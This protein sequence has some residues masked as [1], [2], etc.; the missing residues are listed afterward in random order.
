MAAAAAAAVDP[1][2]VPVQRP[3][4]TTGPIGALLRALGSMRLA[5]WLLLLL[6]ALTWLGTLAQTTRST[7]EVQREYF[8]SWFVLAELEL[9][10]WGKPLW[11]DATGG[12]FK[13]K[14]P[15]PGAYPVM[16][17]LFANLL[18]G[19]FL[20]MRWSLRNLGILVTHVG[21]ALLLVAGFVKMHYSWSGSLA[22]YE[23]PA[24][25][26]LAPGRV[27]Q[28][29]V[30]RSFQEFELA[31]LRQV[32]DRIEE[33]VVP[34]H[35]L[36]GARHGSVLVRGDGLPF[37]IEV[38]H[39]VDFAAAVPKG[40]MVQSQFPE[41]DGAVLLAQ[42]WPKGMQPRSEGEIA[43]CYVTVVANSGERYEAILHGKERLPDD[44]HRYPFTFTV[45]GERYGLDLRHT[46]F[47]LPFGLRLDKFQKLDHP[48]TMT[49]RDFRSFVSVLGGAAARPAEIFMNNPLRQD[50]YVVYQTNWGPQ[51]R[52]GP[53]WLSEFEV[54][55]N[56]SDFW[57]ALA[58][59]VIFVGLALHF[60]TK[61]T[62]F[63]HSSTRTSL[64]PGASAP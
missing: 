61:L 17:L 58:C 15:L 43:G 48:G 35:A 50:G 42:Q 44:R 52:G 31:V 9:S 11:P 2:L 32:G 22:L 39:W 63:L 6:A 24:D 19:G 46:M 23:T 51:P 60:L 1:V 64:V 56:P 29:A 7:Y 26:N 45:A 53:P 5:M 21:I 3:L 40:P 34:E 41:I 18:V 37:T 12:G 8:E 62:R 14:I 49:P 28:S 27:Y 47:E 10:L 33:R 55:Y 20:R 36:W 54:S 25:G 4:A 13:L 30:F 59:I 16:G 38:R 57:P